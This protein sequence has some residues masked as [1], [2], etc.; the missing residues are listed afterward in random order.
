[1]SKQPADR[2]SLLTPQTSD[3]SDSPL[4]P[5]TPSPDLRGTFNRANTMSGDFSDPS[6][7]YTSPPIP[8]I[9]EFEPLDTQIRGLGISDRRQSIQRV[10][11]GS[12]NSIAMSPL[13]PATPS[14]NARNSPNVQFSNSP[15]TSAPGSANPLLSPAWP[16]RGGYNGDPDEQDITKGRN[17]FVDDVDEFG[18]MGQSRGPSSMNDD[19]AR[20]FAPVGCAPEKNL[21]SKRRSWISISILSLSVYSTVLSGIYLALAI[22]QPRYGRAIHSGGE[23]TPETAS[24]LFAGFAKTIELSFVT[25]FVTFLGQVLSRRSL[26]KSSRGVTIAEMTMRTWVVQP[27]FMITHWQALQHVGFTIL[28]CITLTAAFMAMFYTTASDALVSPHLKFGKWENREMFGMVKASY[29]NPGYISDTC[30]TPISKKVDP[31]NAGSTCL[32]VEYAGQAYHNSITFLDTWAAINAEGIGVSTNLSGRPPAPAML[33]D[34]TTVFGT[35]VATN[36]SDMTALYDKYNRIVNNVTLSMPHAGIF[37]AARATRNAILQPEELAGVGEYAIEASVIS[38]TLNVLCVNIN[39]TELAPLIYTEFPQA[40]TNKSAI[41]G[42]KLAYDGYAKDIQ[43]IPGK[44]YLNATVVDDIFRWGPTHKRQP[45]VFP[46]YPIEYNSVTNTTVAHSDSIY[47]LMKAADASTPDYTICQMSSY[48]SPDCSTFYNVS[49]MSGGRLESRCGPD[50]RMAYSRSVERPPEGWPGNAGDWRNVGTLW[51]TALSLNTGISNANSATS[52]LLAQLITTTPNW[53]G[54]YALS[55]L[56]PSISEAL[57]VMAGSTL[58]LSST[59]STFLH[60]WN[61]TATELDP[62]KYEAFNATIT[63][64]QYTSGVTQRWQGMFYIVLALV[65]VTNV[66]CLGY[67]IA[68]SGFVTDFTELQNLFALAVNSPPSS[69]LHGSCGGGPQGDQL[70]TDFHT[71][72]DDAT[73]HFYMKEGVDVTNGRAYE[74]R[75]RNSAANNRHLKSM[76]S[77][78]PGFEVGAGAAGL[79]PLLKVFKEKKYLLPETMDHPVS[80]ESPV[81]T[82]EMSVKSNLGDRPECFK[83]TLQECLFV[84][85]A[86]M[87]I[88]M[89]SFLYGIC[90]VITAP[91]GRDLHMSSAQ[92]TWINASSALSSGAFLLFFAKVADTFGR[93]SLLVFAT[94]AFSVGSLITGF[95][96]NAMYMDVMCGVL[97][98]FSAAAVPPAVGILGAAYA[99]PCKR[100]NYAFAC[101]SAGNP[102]GFVMGTLF[103]GV[104][105][106][107]FNWRAS[108]FLLAIIYAVFFVA[109]L[110]TVPKTQDGF[111]KVEWATVKRFDLVGVGLSITGIVLFC[112]SLTI[113]GDAPQGWSTGYVIAMLVLGL[114]LMV[115]FVGWEAVYKYPLMPLHVWKDKNFSLIN[116]IVLFGFLSFNV[117]AFW[118]SLYMQ[119]VLRFSSLKVAIHLLPMAVSGILVN[120]VAGAVLHKIN[121]KILTGIGALAYLG[122]ALLLA[123]MKADSS[124][125]AF[126]FPFLVL[127]VIGADLEF[128][129][130][131]MYVMSSLP[132]AQQS[133]AGGIFNTVL[134]VCSA[135]GLGISE[136]IYSAESSGHAALQTNIR[137]YTMVFWFCVAGS[138][139]ACLFVPWL[140]IGTQ[141]HSEAEVEV[142][143]VMV[144]E[145]GEKAQGKEVVGKM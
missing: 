117:S 125:W 8:T 81:E 108:F 67:F 23:L 50:N 35:W 29:A 19:T 124:Y 66:F 100:K 116:I 13:G 107:I 32:S 87:S 111:E 139:V 7:R 54:T 70:N 130:A 77:Y 22:I 118:I 78:T 144:V 71:L 110:W 5:S 33:H 37:D 63:S 3:L 129:V 52:R 11:V 104:A 69:R 135:V 42:Q 126:I 74:M 105:S 101:F 36:T 84:L 9:N 38:P 82:P 85:T 34:N 140:S 122:S 112:A 28:G 106:N 123:T 59:D 4:I 12:R 128:N 137:P 10:P 56:T 99:N 43:L 80:V 61:Y 53:N 115:G 103:S 79:P 109:A 136:T 96:T 94:G 55:T 14:T 58:L 60:F 47:M 65:F 142:E 62:G 145:G 57:A 51:I 86:T 88:G 114:V 89:S 72:L 75:R 138:G 16:V 121:N 120:V 133:V 1:M 46:I 20:L 76:S 143:E 68:R 26:V 41:L 15:G 97:G 141:G 95:A 64:Q 30:K 73:G 132:P 92:I 131:N 98:L 25:V 93:R 18:N 39:K 119:N 90:T 49:G 40:L 17:G 6:P 24:I 134:K 45:P 83:S 44:E 21:H 91:I 102:V 127:S 113:G 31:V 27:G 48:V 2:R